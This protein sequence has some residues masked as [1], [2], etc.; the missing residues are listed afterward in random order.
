MQTGLKS[1]IIAFEGM[2]KKLLEGIHGEKYRNY[3]ENKDVDDMLIDAKHSL[4]AEAT[5]E[6]RLIRC[7]ER[8]YYI[9]RREELRIEIMTIKEDFNELTIKPS[10]EVVDLIIDAEHDEDKLINKL[11]VLY[12]EY[13]LISFHHVYL[14]N[15]TR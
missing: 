5:G 8:T 4:T 3:C 15:L 2:H 1:T 7:G 13:A 14:G 11:L 10:E 12:Y 6:Y 9:P